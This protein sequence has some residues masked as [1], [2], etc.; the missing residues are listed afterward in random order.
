MWDVI[1]IGGGMSG[2][3]SAIE[4]KRNYPEMQ[5]AVF[6]RLDRVGK[7]ILATGN[8]RCNLD[9]IKADEKDYNAPHFV[10]HVLDE[11]TPQSNIDFWE[12]L[13]LKVILDEDGRVYPRSNSSQSVLDLLRLEIEKLNIKVIYESVSNITKNKYFKVNNEEAKRVILSAGGASSPKQGSDG[14]GFKLAEKLGHKITPLYP[15]LVQITTETKDVKQLKGIRVKGKLTLTENE[16]TV[17]ESSGE[18]LFADYGLSGIATMDL[19][20]F[21]KNYKRATIYLDMMLDLSEKEIVSYLFKIKNSSPEMQTENLLIGVLP[22]QIGKV[23]L[24]KLNINLGEKIKNLSKKD[25]ENIAYLLKN[26]P[27]NVTGTKG[28]DFSQV[29][30]GGVSLTEIDPVT[31][32]SKKVDNLYFCGEILDV[33]SHCGGYNIHWAVS[34]GRCVGKLKS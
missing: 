28:Y 30:S 12:T 20:R 34:S 26:F 32:M 10:K 17:G 2:L 21:L 29:T 33:D 5:V 4:V 16:K 6:E 22:K 25:F 24:K 18:I 19:S 15:S 14:S 23:I 7:K 31:L 27:F 3:V 11:Y 13:G 9:N 8:G 1:V